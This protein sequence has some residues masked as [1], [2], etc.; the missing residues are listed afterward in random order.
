MNISMRQKPSGIWIVDYDG[1][2]GK[3]KR[4]STGTRDKAQASKLAREIVLGKIAPPAAHPS[5]TQTRAKEGGPTLTDLWDTMLKDEWSPSRTKSQ[6]TLMS[7]IK[8]LTPLIGGKLVKDVGDQDLVD[9]KA[10]LEA[11]G[12]APAT[13]KRKLDM[14]GRSLTAAVRRR[15]IDE[16]PH[17]PVVVV[18]NEKDRI[19]SPEEEALI[20]D[21]IDARAQREPMRQWKR[22]RALVRWL[23]DGGFRLSEPLQAKPDWIVEVK[24]K[25]VLALP[26]EA[27][28]SGKARPVPLTKAIMD[29]VPYLKAT[30]TDDRLFPMTPA[31]AW[32]MWDTIREDIRLSGKGN[33]DDVNLHTFRHTCLTR[34]IQGGMAIHW[35]S[36]WA[37]HANTIITEQRYLR[38][39]AGDLLDAFE[40]QLS[41]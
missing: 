34:L 31:T 21:A 4:I 17:M 29:T 2:D 41:D 6:R 1:E 19:V 38:T 18:K 28:K 36:K 5:Q 8:I 24:G 22:F 7:N 3:R 12:Y 16:R 27:C 15:I 10:A 14:V 40:T 39:N 9:L 33:I 35:V 11:K 23:I 20:F 25:P 13:V 26:P 37:G 32:Y 30:M